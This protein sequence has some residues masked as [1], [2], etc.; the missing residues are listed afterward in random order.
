MGVS[1]CTLLGV[2]LSCWAPGFALPL[3]VGRIC[4]LRYC[5]D[6][7]CLAVYLQHHDV[8]IMKSLEHLPQTLISSLAVLS[9]RDIGS[10][11]KRMHSSRN[12]LPRL[13]R[14]QCAF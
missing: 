10:Y 11:I 5:Y 7:L 6:L 2:L 13:L 3:N 9:V 12:L 4:S 14:L 8:G 1:M